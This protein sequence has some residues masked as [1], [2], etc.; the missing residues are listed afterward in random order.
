MA[1][2]NSGYAK[3][4]IAGLALQIC[5]LSTKAQSVQVYDDRYLNATNNV[6][7]FIALSYRQYEAQIAEYEARISAFRDAYGKQLK[8]LDSQRILIEQKV[9]E[10][11]D[12]LNPLQLLGET[13]KY[14]VQKY[15]YNLTTITDV[16]TPITN[17][18]SSATSNLNGYVSSPENTKNTFRNYLNNNIR[19]TLNNCERNHNASL[20]NYTICV[21]DTI[22][23][24]NAYAS[25]NRNTFNT[26]M[27]NAECS[28]DNRIQVAVEC[29]F[30]TV[31][32]A[33]SNV[34]QVTRLIDDC[35]N[36]VNDCPR[37]DGACPDT[38]YIQFDKD[39][40]YNRTITNPFYNRISDS[41]CMALSLYGVA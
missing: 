40:Y 20:T 33:I 10:L 9:N 17:C 25:N 1:S 3:I 16:R 21:T 7:D 14:C 24:A 28:A 8:P 5:V 4:L 6:Q 23:V 19:S 15:R 13:S 29:S 26:Q 12:R 34:G 36:N 18:I 41:G 32:S 38:T 22:A 11:E 35:L 37:C 27:R 30:T 31:F 2:L 39:Y